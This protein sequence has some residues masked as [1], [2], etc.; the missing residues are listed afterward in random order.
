M[1]TASCAISVTSVL[2]SVTAECVTWSATVFAEILIVLKS[3]CFSCHSISAAFIV[4]F[5][6]RSPAVNDFDFFALICG[7]A[8][9]A[10]AGSNLK[11][12]LKHKVTYLTSMLATIS[13][14]NKSSARATWHELCL[15]PLVECKKENL[16]ALLKS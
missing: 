3:C 7:F 15:K 10:W 13:K 1:K 8:K 5:F 12:W 9:L 14:Q 4:H 11:I 16:V 2:L 6:A